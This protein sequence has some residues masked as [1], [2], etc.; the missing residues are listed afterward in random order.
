MLGRALARR[1]F[2]LLLLSDAEQ[3]ADP[4]VLRGYCTEASKIRA[5]NLPPILVSYG[6]D[7]DPE[8][9]NALKFEAFR[10]R[11][12]K[13][14][15]DDFSTVSDYP[16]NRVSAV[17]R[18]D[19]VIALGGADGVRQLIEIADALGVPMI[20]IAA[21]GGVAE[22]AFYQ[23][24]IYF[25]QLGSISDCLTEYAGNVTIERAG[26]VLAVVERLIE[27]Q[28]MQ[29]KTDLA[30]I[31]AVDVEY[32]QLKKAF[33]ELR[34]QRADDPYITGEVVG[35]TVVAVQQNQMGMPAAAATA[36]QMIHEFRPRFLGM[37]GIVAGIEGKLNLGDLLVPDPSWD[38]GSG[39]VVSEG[40]SGN[41]F[42][43][44]IRQE[45]L[46]PDIKTAV[47]RLGDEQD[48]MNRIIED[49][50]TANVDILGQSGVLCPQT[51][52]K[53]TVGAVASG[54]AVIESPEMVA[55]VRAVQERKLSGIEMEI[56]GMMCAS[57]LCSEPKPKAIPV[58]GASDYAVPGKHDSYQRYAAY[59]SARFLRF[60]VLT[61]SGKIW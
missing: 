46:E 52:P 26:D 48:T 51:P 50:K 54:A 58:K 44:E 18:V 1:R 4:H 21:F 42:Q 24:M 41:R 39:K 47:R 30:V 22:R 57:R 6:S 61:M 28:K 45:R 13:F 34:P 60:L 49:F 55:W 27:R 7:K 9:Q 8:N 11:Y 12:R 31:T 16:F 23:R 37:T 38:Y 53:V 2:Q 15:F 36:M 3:H 33:P 35:L 40:E 20:P 19:A 32:D 25:N 10:K 56:Y 29:Y 17:R 43:L 59:A 14:K 5:N